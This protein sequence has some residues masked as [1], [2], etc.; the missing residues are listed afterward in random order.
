MYS[1]QA[2]NELHLGSI[3]FICL[4]SC[5]Q[6]LECSLSVIY[7]PGWEWARRNIGHWVR[8]LI[9][10]N[11]NTEEEELQ[12]EGNVEDALI[13]GIEETKNEMRRGEIGDTRGEPR[14]TRDE[15]LGTKRET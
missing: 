3:F 10:R 2:A 12:E 13:K 1:F 6:I 9:E 14:E 5:M 11:R 15:G 8:A 7:F 4:P